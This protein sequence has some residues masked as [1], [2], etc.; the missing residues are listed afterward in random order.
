MKKLLLGFGSSTQPTGL[1]HLKW[2]IRSGVW[3]GWEV[4]GGWGEK[5]IY[6]TKIYCTVLAVSVH[7]KA[8][9]LNKFNKIV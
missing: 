3:G 5:D 9:F 8:S 4:W 6:N 1:T 7:Y 2:C